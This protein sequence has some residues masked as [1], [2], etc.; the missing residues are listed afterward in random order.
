MK[1]LADAKCQNTCYVRKSLSQSKRDEKE[2]YERRL[3]NRH[4]DYE[5][6]MSLKNKKTNESSS[7][8]NS[9]ENNLDNSQL[10][11]E[12][13]NRNKEKSLCITPVKETTDSQSRVSS[14]KEEDDEAAQKDKRNDKQNQVHFPLIIR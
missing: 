13:D 1:S 10:S 3:L 8:R 9:N 6:Q 14:R 5:R 7:S 4:R 11:Y 12:A 2:E